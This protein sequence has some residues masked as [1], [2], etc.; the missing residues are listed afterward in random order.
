[1]TTLRKNTGVTG[2]HQADQT[3]MFDIA[4]LA[5]AIH[6]HDP[7]LAGRLRGRYHQF[8]NS[9]ATPILEIAVTARQ[10]EPFIQPVPGDWV[11]ETQF[12]NDRL[13]YTSYLKRGWV[14]IEQGVGEMEV[15]APGDGE[16][17]FRV[18]YAWLCL[19]HNALL[20]HASGLIR[21]G[22]GYAFFGHSGSGKTT[23]TRLSEQVAT[24]LSDDLVILR[25]HDGNCR[26]YGV[27]FRGEFGEAPRANQ[28]AP[29]R[30]IF[31][32]RQDGTHRV[33]PLPP[34]LA[35]AELSASAPFVN[36]KAALIPQLL[37]VCQQI[38]NATQV[39]ALHFKK[40]AKFWETIDEYFE[41]LPQTTSS[42]SR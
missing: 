8:L 42:D 28:N 29:A 18:A 24:I 34:S 20:L 12:E 9:Q 27:P 16:N 31:R 14:D 35:V 15:I 37:D 19:R 32:L 10:G 21:D 13:E 6:I 25:C 30:G 22:F 3:L 40:D 4:G 23:T 38:V 5:V 26:L 7:E 2:L 39:H 11:I 33:Q 1:M 17:F 41:S 36:N